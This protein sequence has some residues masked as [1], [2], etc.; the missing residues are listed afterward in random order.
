MSQKIP[1]LKI[2]AKNNF[3]LG[4]QLGRKLK[5][6]TRRRLTENKKIYKKIKAGSFPRL[7]SMAKNFLPCIK[8]DYPDLLSELDGL[9]QGAGVAFS[10]L[11][12]VMCEE[13]IID[14]KTEHCTS[15]AL[16]IGRQA[17][18]GHNEDWLP[19]YRHNGLYLINASLA[20]KKFLALS[21]MGGLPG[22][23]SGLNSDGFC[24]TANSLNAGRFRYGIPVKFQL[25]AFLG[26]K[27]RQEALRVDLRDSTITS[28]TMLIWKNSKILD[29]EDYFGH[30]QEFYG[31]KFLI[32]TNHPVLNSDRTKDNTDSESVKRYEYVK[33]AFNK[34]KK[35]DVD[36]LKSVLQDHTSGICG[37]PNAKHPTY[38]VTIASI[39]MNPKEKWVALAAGNPCENRYVKYKL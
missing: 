7:V 13:E 38:G 4:L 9:S 20:G 34:R 26:V 33:N 32:H 27:N 25:R 36:F 6:E 10:D 2:K 14:F 35:I 8:K 24:Y 18:I 12:V 29:I 39:I 17:V 22:T 5:T 3:D 23:S 11:L 37:H 28:N 30:H 21:Y 31:R 16:K 1:Y 15:I 19:S